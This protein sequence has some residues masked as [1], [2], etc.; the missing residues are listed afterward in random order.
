VNPEQKEMN[1]SLF[2]LEKYCRKGNMRVAGWVRLMASDIPGT[3]SHM[4]ISE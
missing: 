4:Q 3:H 2:K 1:A